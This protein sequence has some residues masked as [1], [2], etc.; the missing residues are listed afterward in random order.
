MVNSLD[1]QNRG[2]KIYDI[3]FMFFIS[4]ILE[5]VRIDTRATRTVY[6]IIQD[7]EENGYIII[8]KQG[9]ENRYAVNQNLPLRR[10]SQRDIQVRNLLHA[11]TQ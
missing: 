1:S 4:Y 3:L 8:T 5:E 10:E 2:C 9:R 11:I 7:L 6:R